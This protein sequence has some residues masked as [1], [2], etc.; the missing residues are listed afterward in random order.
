MALELKPPDP[1]WEACVRDGFA[2]QSFMAAIGAK[3]AAMS[4]GMCELELPFRADLCQEHAYLHG[5]VL[6]ARTLTVLES[7]VSAEKGGVWR[8][9]ARMLATMMC[10]EGKR[11]VRP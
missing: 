11:E 9:V 8:P 7:E 3:I 5:G 10:L 1:A 2:R 4:P 6:A